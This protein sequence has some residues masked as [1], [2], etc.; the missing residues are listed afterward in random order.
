MDNEFA[1]DFVEVEGLQE[2]VTEALAIIFE[3]SQ[4]DGA[5][6]KAWAIDQTVRKLLGEAQY[7]RFVRAYQFEGLPLDASEDLV[8]DYE[9]VAAGDYYDDEFSSEFVAKVENC[10]Y[11]WDDGIAP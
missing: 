1:K 11:S 7:E 4:V 3:S 9:R 5:H 2:R 6:H 10:Y 8:A